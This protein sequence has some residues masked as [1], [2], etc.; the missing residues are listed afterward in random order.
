M[1]ELIAAGLILTGVLLVLL[2]DWRITVAALFAQY[3]LLGLLISITLPADLHLGADLNSAALIE[4]A[5]GLTV[6]LLFSITARMVVGGELT[7]DTYAGQEL[8]EF[9]QAALRRQRR[10]VTRDAVQARANRRAI[11]GEYLL[12][13]AALLICAT[14]AYSL[15]QLYP[16]GRSPINDFSFYWVVLCGLF[17]LLL[18]RDLIKISI[19]LLVLLNGLGLLLASLGQRPGLLVEGTQAAV[20][21]GLATALSYLWLSLHARLHSLNLD[22]VLRGDD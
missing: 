12:P 2:R 10:R 21:I 22:E 3:L 1:P 13:T 15:S 11:V 4:A 9:Q 18:A 20:T 19:G 16:L 7:A 14:A 5:T 8:D 6:T 17:T